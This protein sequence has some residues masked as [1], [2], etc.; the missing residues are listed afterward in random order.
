M[1]VKVR[2]AEGLVIIK[3]GERQMEICEGGAK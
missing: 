1:K 3:L 2:S